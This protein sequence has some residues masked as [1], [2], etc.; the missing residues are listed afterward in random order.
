L[1]TTLQTLLTNCRQQQKNKE[2]KTD[3][4]TKRQNSN[5]KN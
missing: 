2:T 5:G 1:I 3:R 4:Q